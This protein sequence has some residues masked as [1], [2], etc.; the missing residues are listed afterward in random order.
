MWGV[1]MCAPLQYEKKTS[2]FFVLILS[3][4]IRLFLLSRWLAVSICRSLFHR[5]MEYDLTSYFS[6]H[7][8]GVELVE[9][10]KQANI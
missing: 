3:A 8:V 9:D 6:T 2:L 4:A 1:C 5:F 7:T 10:N